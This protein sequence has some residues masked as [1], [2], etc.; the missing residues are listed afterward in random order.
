MAFL[1]DVSCDWHNDM[2]RRTNRTSTSEW[3]RHKNYLKTNQASLSPSPTGGGG[4]QLKIQ[5]K[6]PLT[7]LKTSLAVSSLEQNGLVVVEL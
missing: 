3:R 5:L 6:A 2:L 1:V 7:I 4:L